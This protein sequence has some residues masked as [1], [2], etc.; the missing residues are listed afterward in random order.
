VKSRIIELYTFRNM[1]NMAVICHSNSQ[2]RLVRLTAFRVLL[3]FGTELLYRESRRV[4]RGSL[5]NPSKD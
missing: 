2:R 3:S 4:Q 5:F 1:E